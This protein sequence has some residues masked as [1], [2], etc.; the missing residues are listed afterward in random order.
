MPRARQVRSGRALY[1]A[2]VCSV[3]CEADDRRALDGAILE[4]DAATIDAAEAATETG[5]GPNGQTSALSLDAQRMRY[6]SGTRLERRLLRRD[7]QVVGFL[8]WYDTVL[9]TLCSFRQTDDGMLRC[10]PT[11]AVS[12]WVSYADA[13]CTMPIMRFDERCSSTFGVVRHASGGCT[14]DGQVFRL[15]RMRPANALIYRLQNGQCVE[16]MAGVPTLGFVEA[17]EVSLTELVSAELRHEVAAGQRLGTIQLLAQ[18][19][20]RQHVGFWDGERATE[21]VFRAT[22]HGERC[23]PK[24][25]LGLIAS[26]FCFSDASR[27]LSTP[28]CIDEEPT[29]GATVERRGCVDVYSLFERGPRAVPLKLAEGTSSAAACS[30]ATATPAY[31]VGEALPPARFVRSDLRVDQRYPG[32][33]KPRFRDAPDGRAWL[34]DWLDDE[35]G[36]PCRFALAS[37]KTVCVPHDDVPSAFLGYDDAACSVQT[38]YASES[39]GRC[40]EA[41]LPVFDLTA[42]DSCPHDLTVERYDPVVIVGP[43][44]WLAFEYGGP[45]CAPI[46]RAGEI[47]RKRTTSVPLSS[48]VAA[49]PSGD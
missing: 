40:A 38:P 48:L 30:A 45:R 6:V 20:A 22:D 17:E 42:P 26:T 3:A 18:D 24:N 41:E 13:A 2:L 23:I 19:G 37:G 10:V 46:A 33:L 4:L 16:D 11:P 27:V 47:L 9:Q 5:T 44:Y 29:V 12:S 7:G 28:T 1:V 32:R 39:L 8:G 35:L 34:E 43:V 31:Q 25:A 21:C 15:S 36:V 14:R 49:E